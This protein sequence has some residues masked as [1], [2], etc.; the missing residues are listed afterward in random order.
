MSHPAFDAGWAQASAPISPA[1]ATRAFDAAWDAPPQAPAPAKPPLLKRVGEAVLGMIEHPVKTAEAMVTAP[2]Q[3]VR[4]AMAPGSAQDVAELNTLGATGKGGPMGVLPFTKADIVTPAQRRAALAQVAV[5]A[6]AP[7]LARV[8][9]VGPTVTGLA[10]GAAYDPNDPLVGAILG[11]GLGT[12][13]HVA[14]KVAG[15]AAR[16]VTPDVG[17]AVAQAAADVAKEV[18][19]APKPSTEIPSAGPA[20]ES[21]W[22]AAQ[23]AEP[24][25]TAAENAAKA[26]A[27]YDAKVAA[28]NAAHEAESARIAQD[29]GAQVKQGIADAQA[30]ADAQAA[31]EAAG[32][33]Q[34]EATMGSRTPLGVETG[35]V[36]RPNAAAGTAEPPEQLAF[37][38]Q[39]QPVAA[40]RVPTP[41][42][43]KV[44]TGPTH[45]QALNTVPGFG[46]GTETPPGMEDGFLTTTGRFVGRDEAMQLLERSAA[47]EDRAAAAAIRGSN[48][49]EVTAAEIAKPPS[50]PLP[51]YPEGFAMGGPES[52]IPKVVTPKGPRGVEPPSTFVGPEAANALGAPAEPSLTPR[53]TPKGVG[54]SGLVN[55]KAF[56]PAIEAH[57]DLFDREMARV[58]A[59]GLDKGYV[60]FSEQQKV[61]HAFADA[62]GVDRLQLD[63][64]RFGRMS[65]AEIVGMKEALT[66]NLDQLEAQSRIA[67]DAQA[68]AGDRATAQ[69]AISQIQAQNEDLL[70]GIVHGSSEAGRSLG[71]LRQIAQRT[72][73]PDVWVVQAQRLAGNVP[74]SDDVILTIRKMAREAAEACAR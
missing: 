20:F 31:A 60:P 14:P 17:D 23:A 67:N 57:P 41:E 46:A 61:A 42:G 4:T 32:K 7:E 44:Y 25:V 24:Q 58:S 66:Q 59:K 2:L 51:S 40:L 34:F 6:V 36:R 64:R 47:P 27:A 50:G 69:A 39:G 65:G 21:A 9:V 3:S 11:G 48:F 16:A 68:T 26:K 63:R 54:A 30:K 43:E 73:D 38:A 72:L 22:Q 56:A 12:A 49:P 70:A 52:R 1:A 45:I 29:I 8:P 53:G 19:P 62:V 74:L 55:P 5:N 18:G 28:I 13:V 35:I 15:A 37:D 71:F 33:A 10:A